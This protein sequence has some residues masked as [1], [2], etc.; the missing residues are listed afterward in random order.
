MPLF[1]HVHIWHLKPDLTYFSFT[2]YS[3][4]L[5]MHFFDISLTLYTEYNTEVAK[6]TVKNIIDKN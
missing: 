5:S 1:V 4:P 6:Y 3:F 2:L